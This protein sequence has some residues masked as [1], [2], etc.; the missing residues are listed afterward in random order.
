MQSESACVTC[1]AA[2]QGRQRRFCSRPCKNAD[3]N[4]RHQSYLSQQARGLQRKL[5]LVEEAGG[6]CTSCGYSRNLAA[7]TWHHVEPGKK[8]FQL[9]MRSLSNRSDAAV[10]MELAKCVLLCANCHAEVH[11]PEL[12]LRHLASA[13]RNG[14]FRG[15]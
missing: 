12:D 10:R 2:L 7:L 5:A 11:A 9:D 3:T 8:H 13:R 1:G 15:R 14:R 6:R 4:H